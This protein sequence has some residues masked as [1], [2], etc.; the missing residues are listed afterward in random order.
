MSLNSLTVV[1]TWLNLPSC[2]TSSCWK[3]L[4]SFSCHGAHSYWLRLVVS[5]VTHTHTDPHILRVWH[6]VITRISKTKN[7][8]SNL[9]RVT[10]SSWKLYASE[11]IEIS[12]YWSHLYPVCLRPPLVCCRCGSSTLLW[13]HSGPLHLQQSVSWVS[14]QNQTGHYLFSSFF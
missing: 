9:D 6:T 1:S 11:H 12:A 10:V 4:C 7:E 14:G 8:I 3:Q 2:E 5:Q 13:N